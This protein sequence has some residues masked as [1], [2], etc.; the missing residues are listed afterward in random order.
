MVL[1]I[2]T[3]LQQ[4]T[5]TTNSLHASANIR[6]LWIFMYIATD[7]YI[8]S[9]IAICYMHSYIMI[10][11]RTIYVITIYHSLFIKDIATVNNKSL[12]VQKFRNSLDFIQI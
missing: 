3:F 7:I 1:V 2:R 6:V 11:I 12:I 8:R 9:Y 10:Y 4:Y 5:S